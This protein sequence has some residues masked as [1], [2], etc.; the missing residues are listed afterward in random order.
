[1]EKTN[2]YFE[3]KSLPR[4]FFLGILAMVLSTFPPLAL[5]APVP[6][7]FI[8]LQHGKVEALTVALVSM[9]LLVLLGPKVQMAVVFIAIYLLSFVYAV[10]VSEII[11]RKIPP[12]RG[13]VYSGL[14]I[15]SVIF[16]GISILIMM[17]EGSFIE[18]LEK[19]IEQVFLQVKTENADFIARGG[20]EARELE[21]FISN[22][23]KM[24]KEV[25]S[26]FPSLIFVSNFIGLWVAF[27]LTLRNSVSWKR[28]VDYPYGTSDLLNFKIPDFFVWPLILSLAVYVG[29]EYLGS[30]GVIVGGNLLYS[31]GVFYFFQG[32]GIFNKFLDFWSIMGIFRS[33]LMVFTMFFAWRAVVLLGVLGIWIDFKRFMK[34]KEE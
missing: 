9:V 2:V 23:Q 4:M 26:W 17:T 16:I 6:M 22:P 32:F 8:F 13:L 30:W 24:V 27:F 21:D 29:G 15:V 28:K 1:M 12:M 10:S 7:I 25:I 18:Q 5:F 19:S 3:R 11:Y 31:L 14:T 20:S 33:F 34:K